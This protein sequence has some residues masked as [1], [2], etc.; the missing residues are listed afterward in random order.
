QCLVTVGAEI[1]PGLRFEERLC[2]F[3]VIPFGDRDTLR[4][5][6]SL[7]SDNL[8]AASTEITA[9]GVLLC[10]LDARRDISSGGGIQRLE[11]GDGVGFRLSLGMKPLDGETTDSD[12]G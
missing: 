4:R 11:L 6:R 5:G 2:H 7:H 3:E 12:A 8:S 10:G 1:G 9:T